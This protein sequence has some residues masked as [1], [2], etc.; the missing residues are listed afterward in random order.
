MGKK[1]DRIKKAIR[2]HKKISISIASVLIVILIVVVFEYEYVPGYSYHSISSA[3]ALTDTGSTTPGFNGFFKGFGNISSTAYLNQ[4]GGDSYIRLNVSN[5]A[6]ALIPSRF[7]FEANVTLQG[8]IFS[9][10][11]PKGAS[12]IVS[13]SPYTS[14]GSIPLYFY[15]Y[16][17]NTTSTNQPCLV[18]NHTKETSV[19]SRINLQNVPYFDFSGNYYNFKGS[20]C[21][22]NGFIYPPASANASSNLTISFA[23][24]VAGLG[25]DV[26]AVVDLHL[27]MNPI[28]V[29]GLLGNEHLHD[30]QYPELIHIVNNETHQNYNIT[31][32]W[33]AQTHSTFYHFLA[34]P[35]SQY[36][37][38]YNLNGAWYN[39]SIDTGAPDGFHCLII[40]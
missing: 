8:H 25:G 13:A 1:F 20:F 10:L 28:Y 19:T 39:R 33:A 23:L 30:P 16:A 21:P 38:S 27:V 18:F 9:D 2:S 40:Q 11:H 22:I 14:I 6:I 17:L 15:S 35:H 34:L 12:L 36:F 26:E 5:A 32:P 24:K 29:I 31:V 4:S 3:A 37:M 7:V